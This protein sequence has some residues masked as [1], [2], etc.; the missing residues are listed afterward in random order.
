MRHLL[1]QLQFLLIC[2]A[3]VVKHTETEEKVLWDEEPGAAELGH[4]CTAEV[5]NWRRDT[6]QCEV[7]HVVSLC[8]TRL[9]RV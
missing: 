1:G 5:R 3:L 7:N 2:L 4:L 8:H 6:S 9:V